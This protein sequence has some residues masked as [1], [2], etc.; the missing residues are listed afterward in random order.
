MLNI[1][2]VHFTRE[3]PL[4][5]SVAD[6]L[7]SFRRY[8][9]DRFHYLNAGSN[10]DRWFVRQQQFDAIIFHNTFF[11]ARWSDDHYA[12]AIAHVDFLKDYG[13]PKIAIV[14]DEFI[15]TDRVCAMIRNFG[16]QV[17]CSVA[18]P[19]ERRKIYDQVDFSQTRFVEVLTGYL[20]QDTFAQFENSS[21]NR[22]GRPIDIGVDGCYLLRPR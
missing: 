16:M 18:S 17:V 4:R 22:K 10:G 2:V 19:S 6:H 11:S 20:S 14:Q 1:L 9:K 13:C 15:Y 5:I 21:A 3:R 8:G 7:F 12:R